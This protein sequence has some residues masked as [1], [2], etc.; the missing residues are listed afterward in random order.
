MGPLWLGT[1][2]HRYIWL[3]IHLLPSGRCEADEAESLE[4][5]PLV[6]AMLRD[7][8]VNQPILTLSV[9]K[10][11]VDMQFGGRSLVL[12]NTYRDVEP[13]LWSCQGQG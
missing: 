6:E 4:S 12:K 1:D 2:P 8:Q 13:P 10:V 11:E 5:A 9:R 3:V 7:P